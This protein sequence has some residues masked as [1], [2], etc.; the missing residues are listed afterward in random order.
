MQRIRCTQCNTPSVCLANCSLAR[1]AEGREFKKKYV[2][3]ERTPSTG[4]SLSLHARQSPLRSPLKSPVD[5][6]EKLAAE[7]RS[8]E[9]QQYFYWQIGARR[10]LVLNATGDCRTAGLAFHYYN[11]H[12]YTY[13]QLGEFTWACKESILRTLLRTEN[14]RRAGFSGRSLCYSEQLWLRL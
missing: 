2:K 8:I 1:G 7:V 14:F 5:Q 11:E 4:E 12:G 10:S 9:P 3:T 6:R 13:T